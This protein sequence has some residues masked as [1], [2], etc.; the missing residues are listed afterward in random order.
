MA[1]KRKDLTGQLDGLFSDFDA[2]EEAQAEEERLDES[3]IIADLVEAEQAEPAAAE[4]TEVSAEMP[5]IDVLLAAEP[6]VEAAEEAEEPQAEQPQ[7]EP[8]QVEPAGVP[9]ETPAIDDLLAAEPVAAEEAEQPEPAPVEPEVIEQAEPA[10][11]E[12]EVSEPVELPTMDE[13][14]AAEEVEPAEPALAKEVLPAVVA[15][16]TEE[17]EVEPEPEPVAREGV[18]P[19]PPSAPPAWELEIQEQRTRILNILLVAMSVVATIIVSTL[20]IFSLSDPALWTTYLPFFVAWV[21]LLG[22]NLF[23]GLSTTVRTTILVVLAYVA[24]IFSLYIDG[25][26][27][28]G[29]MYLLLAPILFSIL[30]QQRAG[31]YAAIF[32]FITYVSF[33]IAHHLGW[34]VSAEVLDIARWEVVMN[35]GS[36][37]FMLITAVTL[38]QWLFNS[39]LLTSLREVEE[40]HTAA[41]RSQDALRERAEELAVANAMLQ[42]RSLQLET[43]SQVSQ[44]ASSILDPEELMQQVVD[45]IQERFG[46]Y[47]VGLFLSGEEGIGAGGVMLRAGTGEAGRRMLARGYGVEI[48][49]DSAV[50][51]CTARGQ[52]HIVPDA[53]SMASGEHPRPELG[54]KAQPNPSVEPGG[55]DVYVG[56]DLLPR[57]RSEIALPLRSRGRVLGALDAHSAES[58]AF[59][60]EDI[61]ILQAM[62]DNIAVTIDN[63]RLFAELRRRLREMEASQRLYVREQWSELV[64][65]RVKPVYQRTSPEVAPLDGTAL[66]E[67][68]KIVSQ[69]K[70][71]VQSDGNGGT[72]QVAVVTPVTLRGEV[73]GAL[74]LQEAEGRRQWTEDEIALIDAVADQMALAIENVRLLEETRQLAGWEQTLSD[75]TARFTRSLDT[76]TLLQTAIQELG[77]LLQ[78]DEVSVH[79]GTLGEPASADE[80]EGMGNG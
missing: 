73:I 3:Q 80:D 65:R 4:P 67:V 75:M 10:E 52:A 47:Y 21:L 41:V 18:Q 27:G 23:R 50:G 32:S 46:L 77:Q 53:T 45:L 24:G 15:E 30:V 29:G 55:E 48:G 66:S 25:P 26:L 69:Q 16:A 76:E 78:V 59:S 13:L 43:A 14:L 58:E 20:V 54:S 56:H 51:Q 72:D 61:A 71:V 35:L 22:L 62:A 31:V 57:T 33:A 64:P 5:A 6:A 28:A 19:A 74:G 37:F 49:D 44:A 79:I 9:A 1:K 39:S 17:A 12:H 2:E 38:L 60:Q 42:R 7:A 11:A 68:E 40:K 36:T 8:A 70:A 34:I 63:A